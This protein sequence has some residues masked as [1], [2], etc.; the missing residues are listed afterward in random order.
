VDRLK[1]IQR[2]RTITRDF[3]NSIFRENDIIDFINEGVN[4]CKQVI[5]E[6]SGMTELYANTHV[7]TLLPDEYHYLLAVYSASRCF[8][9]DERHYQASN[10]MN[11]FESKLDELYSKIQNGEV[12]IKDSSGNVITVDNDVDYVDT[13][14]YFG[15]YNNDVDLGVEGVR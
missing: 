12:T 5:P 10:Y 2:V 8:G 3:N 15:K 4:R 7:P 13:S 9:Q 11:E 14:D 1:L 6:F